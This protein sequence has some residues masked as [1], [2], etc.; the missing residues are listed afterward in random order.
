MRIGPK[1]ITTAA[2]VAAALLSWL[3]ASLAA[4]LIEAR[5][6][7]AVRMALIEADHEWARV[8][9]DGLQVHIGGEAPSEADRFNALSVSG[10]VVEASRVIDGTT[11]RPARPIAPPEFTVEILRNDDGVQLI[12]LV[13]AALDRAAM[14]E[15][16]AALAEGAEVTDFL[17]AVDYPVPGQWVPSLNFALD[18]LARLPRSKVSVSAGAVSITAIS[19]SREEQ[20]EL[21]TLL[22]R[23]APDD[24]QLDLQISAP[25]PVI[26]P[27]TLRFLMDEAG[28]RFDACSADN[29][30]GRERILRAAKNAGL[31][32]EGTCTLGLGVP[33]PEWANG[34]TMAIESLARLGSGSLTFS[35]ADV[36]L[37]AAQGTDPGLFDEVVGALESNLPEVFSLTAVLPEPEADGADEGPPPPEFTATR[38]PEG[39]VQLRGRLPN[40]VVHDMVESFA[41]AR[42]GVDKVYMAARQEAEGLPEAWP[43][44]VLA[45]LSALSEVDHG[46]VTVLA[47]AV[48]LSGTSGN[49]DARAEIARLMA[50]KLGEG[51]DISLDVA[52][53]ER[54]DPLADLPTPDECIRRIE[55]ILAADKITFA[56]GST[57]VEGESARVVDDIAE[58]LRDCGDVD[59][60]V[61]IAGHT[62]SQGRE[63]MNLELSEAR[64]LAVL[65]AL[66]DRRVRIGRITSKGYGETV[67]IADNDTEEGREANRRIEF[68]LIAGEGE[69]EGEGED[70]AA[71]AEAEPGSGDAAAATE[72]D[73]AESAEVGEAAE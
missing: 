72:T 62:D 6:H 67:P 47:D 28:A 33:T 2:L 71:D 43:V 65:E 39:D 68:R 64:A 55:V 20:R 11:V 17:E 53:D 29:E 24:L 45:G 48:T 19:G 70:N 27:F 15:E 56:P 23:L 32:E 52:Y 42:F 61:E 57:A 12:G 18:A 73:A 4:G 25:R 49:P 38:S 13:P 54:L 44:R 35:D 26:T 1:V 51:A 31:T 30:R 16:I 66:A 7:A 41:R 9:T 59:M 40:A 3:S 63:E 37:I 10:R 21:E 60:R 22:T 8:H 34:V 5:S 69:G 36:A 50:E 46:T 58:V 14:A